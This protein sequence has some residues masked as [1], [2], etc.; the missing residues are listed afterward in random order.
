MAE[1]GAGDT[2]SYLGFLLTLQI[3]PISIARCALCHYENT[4]KKADVLLE[5]AIFY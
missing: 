5:N 4:S 1:A 3:V 2:L